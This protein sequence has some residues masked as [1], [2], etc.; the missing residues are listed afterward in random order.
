MIVCLRGENT[1]RRSRET[2]RSE[3]PGAK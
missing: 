3:I 2:I 1:Q